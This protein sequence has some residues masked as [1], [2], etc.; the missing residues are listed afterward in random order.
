MFAQ[1]QKAASVLILL[2]LLLSACGKN[3][4]TSNSPTA[5][6]KPPL[7]SASTPSASSNPTALGGDT[8]SPA[9][10]PEGTPLRSSDR[11]SEIFIPAGWVEDRTLNSSADIQAA[12]AS[13]AMYIIVLSDSKAD[14]QNV[15]LVKHSQLTRDT[16]L[17]SLTS[18]Q[19]SP[20]TEVKSVGGNPAIQYQIR[21]SVSNTNVVYLHTTIET[22]T[23]FHQILAWTLPSAFDKNEPQLQQIIQSFREVK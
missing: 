1:L 8:Q 18:P 9:A 22:P 12:K 16:L 14:L 3:S 19:V 4:S 17:K 23:H 2:P 7:D 5:D 11:K 10:Q 15:S 21:A 20:P 6:S 13:E